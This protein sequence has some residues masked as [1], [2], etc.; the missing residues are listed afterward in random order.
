MI[1]IGFA[2]DVISIGVKYLR[3]AAWDS[4]AG[5]IAKTSTL[6]LVLTAA[7]NVPY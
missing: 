5:L 1:G 4:L 2:V 6:G 7:E 3:I